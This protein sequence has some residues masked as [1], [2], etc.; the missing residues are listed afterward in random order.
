[1][2]GLIISGFDSK[3]VSFFTML[4]LLICTFFLEDFLMQPFVSMTVQKGSGR[5]FR[6]TS[7]AKNPLVF[8]YRKNPKNLFFM[9]LFQKR[10]EVIASIL[11]FL[12][13]FFPFS[14]KSCTLHPFFSELLY[15]FFVFLLIVEFFNF[16]SFSF[17]LCTS[18]A[19]TS[20]R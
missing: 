2:K 10:D 5:Q 17:A 12:P 16:S 1:M 9:R 15:C 4:V 3:C 7:Q 11:R 6:K 19:F 18:L 14:N 20:R 8:F 13:S